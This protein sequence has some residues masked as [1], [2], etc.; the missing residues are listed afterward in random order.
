[1]ATLRTGEREA[2]LCDQGITPEVFV[3]VPKKAL[4]DPATGG[5]SRAGRKK[6]GRS[7]VSMLFS[8]FKDLIVDPVRS[9]VLQVNGHFDP[10]FPGRTG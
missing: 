5:R 2:C 9:P 8:E 10:V 1:M 3:Q 6:I 4:Q 7:C